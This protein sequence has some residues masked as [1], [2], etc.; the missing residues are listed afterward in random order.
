MERLNE[1]LKKEIIFLE[2]SN[3]M[4]IKHFH[5]I[6]LKVV[7]NVVKF[8]DNILPKNLNKLIILLPPEMLGE[9][10]RVKE[11]VSKIRKGE[12]IC[13]YGS[14]IDKNTVLIGFS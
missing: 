11:E 3:M 13:I 2:L 7:N 10:K 14:N 8:L 5:M 12:I 9:C 6:D 4:S 1:L